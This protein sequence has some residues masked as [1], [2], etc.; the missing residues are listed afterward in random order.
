MSLIVSA[1]AVDFIPE[2]IHFRL[3]TCCVEKYPVRPIL[4]RNYSRYHLTKGAYLE[5][6]YES[7]KYIVISIDKKRSFCDD[8]GTLCRNVRHF[9]NDKLH[10]VK[11][12]G[13]CGL[14]F[15]WCIQ[16]PGAAVPVDPSKLICIDGYEPNNDIPLTKLEGRIPVDVELESHELTALNYWFDEQAEFEIKMKGCGSELYHIYIF[17]NILII[18]PNCTYL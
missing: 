5:L 15:T 3:M 1:K 4:K 9:I 12:N 14:Q 17:C 10:E 7:N 16:H 6:I 8:L 13:F 11:R 2:S 18:P